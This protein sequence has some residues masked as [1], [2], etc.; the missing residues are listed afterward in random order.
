M[1]AQDLTSAPIAGS[2]DFR[3]TECSG[4]ARS[5]PGHDACATRSE[6][7]RPAPG[8]R[9]EG[10][11]RCMRA[12]WVVFEPELSLVISRADGSEVYVLRHYWEQL[13]KALKVVRPRRGERIRVERLADDTSGR[14]QFHVERRG[15]E[16]P[17]P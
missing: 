13:T 7:W 8:D 6:L 10:I 5:A 15:E 11:V 12:R 16:D 4:R 1:T 3:A 2:P 14:R 17:Q 9:V